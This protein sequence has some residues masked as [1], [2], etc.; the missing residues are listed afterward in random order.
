MK[1][2]I[3]GGTRYMG[4]LAVEE[5]LDRGDDV[6]VYSRGNAKPAWWDRVDH[7][8]G[9]RTDRDDFRAKL[10]GRSFDAVIDT[11]AFRKEDVESAFET[12]HGSCGRYLMVSTGSVYM[13]D[14]VDYSQQC[15]FKESDVDW[16]SIDYTYPE[17][18][19]AYGV[20]KR[21][22]EK[23]LQEHSRIPYTIIRVPAVSTLLAPLL[24]VVPLQVF[25]CELASAKGLDV[26]QPRNLAKSVTVE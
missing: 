24:T 11:R 17:G 16:S 18:Q 9:D 5:M 20:G 25:A 19:D 15:P 13:R 23:W 22:C 7:I 4:R 2:L 3:I 12:L 6:T 21:H 1:V 10:K 8:A 26:D 14:L